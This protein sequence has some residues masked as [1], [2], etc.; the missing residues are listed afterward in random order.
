MKKFKNLFEADAKDYVQK[1]D[2]EQEELGYKLRSKGEQDFANLHTVDKKKHPT[3]PDE[4]HDGE[5]PKGKKGKAGMD[6]KGPSEKGDELPMT[7]AKFMK[8]ALVIP[9]EKSLP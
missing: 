9:L 7:Y 2:D 5:R 1:D 3:A 6:A 4:Q 8:L